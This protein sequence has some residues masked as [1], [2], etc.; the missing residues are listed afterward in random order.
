[1]PFSQFVP[2]C[3]SVCL[4]ICLT[5]SLRLFIFL[6]VRLSLLRAYVFEGF[7]KYTMFLIAFIVDRYID[8]DHKL[9]LHVFS[10]AYIYVSACVDILCSFLNV[11]VCVCVCARLCEPTYVWVGDFACA[12]P[13]PNHLSQRGHRVLKPII[14]FQQLLGS[15]LRFPTMVRHA[16]HTFTHEEWQRLP[17]APISRHAHSHTHKPNNHTDACLE[18]C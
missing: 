7:W 1:M 3:L 15:S 13:A 6:S 8:W 9:S 14:S 18:N 12:S 11:C 16:K 2:V 17:H 4:C 5:V 10:H